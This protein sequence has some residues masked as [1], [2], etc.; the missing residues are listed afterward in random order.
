MRDEHLPVGPDM[1]VF[2]DFPGGDR[3]PDGARTLI[4]YTFGPP[5]GTRLVLWRDLDDLGVMHRAL[6]RRAEASLDA[7]LGSARLHGSAPTYMVS[8]HG[9]EASLLLSDVFWEGFAADVPGELVIGAPARDVL[10]VT[11]SESRAGVAKAWRCV[12]RVFFAGGPDLLIRDLLVWRRG[13]RPLDEAAPTV[14]LPPIPPVAI[15]PVAVPPM[16]IPAEGPAAGPTAGSIARW[17]GPEDRA[18]PPR[19]LPD[20]RVDPTRYR[21]H[22]A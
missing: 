7:M 15:S 12:D 10:V 9:V 4:A 14:L 20:Q 13:W 11:G 22:Y 5:F 2:D 16:V 21:Y 3:F 18:L 1:P 19:G 8:F 6:R 17:S